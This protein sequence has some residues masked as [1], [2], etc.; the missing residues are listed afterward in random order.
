VGERWKIKLLDIKVLYKSAEGVMLTANKKTVFHHRRSKELTKIGLGVYDPKTLVDKGTFAFAEIKNVF[1]VLPSAYMAVDHF[2]NVG[3]PQK[4]FRG[5][6]GDSIFIKEEYLN[7][8]SIKAFDHN[9]VVLI[10]EN[11][12][13]KNGK[14]NLHYYRLDNVVSSWEDITEQLLSSILLSLESKICDIELNNYFILFALK[15][16]YRNKV[17]KSANGVIFATGKHETLVIWGNCTNFGM[18]WLGRIVEP[19]GIT[20]DISNELVP[21]M[22]ELIIL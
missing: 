15:R 10:Q 19:S 3:V 16:L 12:H 7:R 4:V 9:G 5:S 20:E 8:T 14:M 13:L 17:V 1:S 2:E 21:L 11:T 18:S 22:Q 6:Y